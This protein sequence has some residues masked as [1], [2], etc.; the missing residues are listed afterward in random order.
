M[1]RFLYFVHIDW[2]KGYKGK[3]HKRQSI[4]PEAALK[5]K[6]LQ[7]SNCTH[8]TCGENKP[9]YDVIRAQEI[10]NSAQDEQQ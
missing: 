2:I 9:A 7:A 8:K 4:Y 1:Q 3:A 10:Q 6:R 5:V